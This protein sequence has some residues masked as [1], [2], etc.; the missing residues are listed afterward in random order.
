MDRWIRKLGPYVGSL[1]ILACMGGFV[2][3]LDSSVYRLSVARRQPSVCR[4]A[5]GDA[6][7]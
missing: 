2:K 1:Q 6:N 3:N 4:N 7:T 5:F